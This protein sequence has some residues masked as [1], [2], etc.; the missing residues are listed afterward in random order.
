MSHDLQ[1]QRGL[2]NAWLS[3]E[4]LQRSWNETTTQHSIALGEARGHAHLRLR[5]TIYFF[6]ERITHA[7]IRRGPRGRIAS[8]L[9]PLRWL[10]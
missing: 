7:K 2:A 10:F 8:R 3:A 4:E 5:D 1:E 6:M 9:D